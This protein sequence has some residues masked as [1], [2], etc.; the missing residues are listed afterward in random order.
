[1]KFRRLWAVARKE[2]IQLRR[3][4][5]SLA[6]AFALPALLLLLFG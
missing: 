5:R 4:T 1:M 2:M 6:L 3:D